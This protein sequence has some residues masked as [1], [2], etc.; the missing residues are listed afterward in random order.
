MDPL[1]VAFDV[2]PLAGPRTG[3]GH[4]VAAMRDSLGAIDDLE[5]LEY[6]VSFLFW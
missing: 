4:A 5:L 6:V 2:G 1:R 3:V